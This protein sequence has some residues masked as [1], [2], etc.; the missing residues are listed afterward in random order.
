MI[1]DN[2]HR[3][4]PGDLSSMMER[5]EKTLPARFGETVASSKPEADAHGTVVC[6]SDLHSHIPVQR[7]IAEIIGHLGE[8]HRFRLL[9]VEGASGEGDTSFIWSL[10]RR[11]RLSF[12]QSLFQK[13]YLTGSEFAVV[14]R[15]EL[16][17]T[18]WGVDVPP[19]YRAQWRAFRDNL[20]SRPT[21]VVPLL[22]S[23]RQMRGL[24]EPL[25]SRELLR[26]L[27]F[28]YTGDDHWN[29]WSHRRDSDRN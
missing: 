19:L 11:T 26:L 23:R 13:G 16:G 27:R 24:Y 20:A 28:Q 5:I 21:F 25:V 10:P 8:H 4:H 3:I 14:N 6:I 22:E 15:P 12:C 1:V 9:C 29:T 17:F 18:L 2:G 7:N